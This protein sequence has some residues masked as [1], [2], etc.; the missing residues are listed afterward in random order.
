MQVLIAENAG[1]CYG[2]KRALEM[3]LNAPASGGNWYTLGPLVH[4]QR[5]TKELSN[6]GIELIEDLASIDTGGIIIRAHGV[7]PDVLSLARD[8]GLAIIDATCPLVKKVQDK[9]RKMAEEG[10]RVVIVGDKEH[11]E[12]KGI[13][14]WAGPGA[15]VVSASEDVDN[16]PWFEKVAVVSQ[17]TKRTVE[18]HQVVAELV[19]HTREIRAHNTICGSTAKRQAMSAKLARNVDLMVVIGDHSSSNTRSLV[20][21]CEACGVTTY[22]IESI[23]DLERRWFSGIDRVGVT[24]GASTP[25][26][27][28]KEVV[29]WMSEIDA[30][31]AHITTDEAELELNKANDNDS[32]TTVREASFA[33]LEAEMAETMKEVERGTIIKGTI[34]QINNDEVMVDVGGKS[35]GIIPLREL[36]THDISSPKEVV[37]VGD[38]VK[39]LVLRWD[40]DGTILLSK[41]RVDQEKVLDE[42]QEAF[43]ADSIV[44]GTVLKLVKGGLL[45]DLGVVGFLPASQVE[46][47]YVK[48]LENYI[49]QDLEYRI[50]EFN[51]NKRRG[52]QVV[53]SRRKLL[54]AEKE[55]GKQ[56]FWDEI[57]EGQV[58]TGK[59]KRLTDYGAFIDL[60]GFE[61]LLHIS[62]IDHIR[63]NK[64]SDVLDEGQEI[65]VYVLN[66]N[67][68]TERVS[69][70]RK[71]VLKSPWETALEEFPVGS[72]VEGK[73]VRL[74]AFGAFVELR[75]GVD[76]LVH[77]SQLAN[78]RVVNTE[79]VVKVEQIVKVKVIGLDPEKRRIGLSIKEADE[80]ADDKFTR[81]YIDNQQGEPT[82]SMSSFEESI[83]PNNQEI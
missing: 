64:P 78:R 4:N 51:R 70:S 69:L 18:Y 25:D 16:L 2:V 68:E 22:H 46:D 36:S 61:G 27:L 38:E 60:G 71:R 66:A 9:A 79:D 67:P 56:K 20:K 50:L 73:V 29:D 37:K 1:F 57:V 40:D 83:Q 21:V 81:E 44:R 19:S 13:L 7:T 77:I 76:G 10:Y 17:T 74:A 65:E 49:G 55:A 43:N 24:A 5:V 53:V 42:L 12:V 75:P 33:Q 82:N 28:I 31:A 35:E 39:V 52:S 34:I 23:K 62:E 14:G 72:I 48:D 41:R 58:R 26:W 47:G 11:P 8:K 32:A 15:M 6:K 45:V 54:E 30:N 59:V 3:A 63:I 80:G